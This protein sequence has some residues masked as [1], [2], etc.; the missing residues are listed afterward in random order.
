MDMD[1]KS[2]EILDFHEYRL[3]LLRQGLI[4]NVNATQAEFRLAYSARATYNMTSLSPTEW[5]RVVNHM[6]V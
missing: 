3:D 6:K 5:Y 2:G 4:N 1:S